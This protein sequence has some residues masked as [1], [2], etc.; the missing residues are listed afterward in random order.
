ML[1]W[2]NQFAIFAHGIFITSLIL[3][4]FPNL[5]YSFWMLLKTLTAFGLLAE[6]GL[7]R[8]IE[9][10][11]AF[12]YAGASRLP[13]NKTEFSEFSKTLD[14]VNMPELEK[15]LYT[16]KYIYLLLSVV[17]ILLLTTA[18]IAVLSNL[19]TQSG[20]D[21]R[22]WIAFILMIVQSSVMLQR[23]KWRSFMA[24]TKHLKEL[25]RLNTLVSVIRIFGFLALLLNNLGLEYLMAYLVV[26]QFVTYAYMRRFMNRWFKSRGIELKRIFKIDKTIFSSIWSVSW[27]TSLNS[28]GFFF[29]NRGVDLIIAQLKDPSLMAAYLFT[30][31]I[32]RF[33]R[34]IAQTPVTVKY[35]I[36][37]GLMSG[38]KFDQ[39]KALLSPRIFLS[40][41]IMIIG[42]TS[43]GLLGNWLLDLIGA[44][45]KSIV[46]FTIFVLLS[47]FLVFESHALIMGTI[48]VS[49]ND[50]PFLIPALITGTATVIIGSFVLPKWGLLGLISLQ[51]VL[52]L[53]NN[54]WYSAYLSL[55]LI[56]W[57]LL[58]YVKDV[59]IGGPRY[60]IS[61]IKY[62]K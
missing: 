24:G 56:H 3:V 14:T 19:F 58:T 21:H 13:K 51:M 44:E 2:T 53:G 27:K 55:R 16:I 28:W 37:Y 10:S 33:I 26:E 30:N 29:S 15:L 18:G 62:K 31:S 38:K 35:P 47:V 25:Y 9:R 40:L 4:K 61:R 48:Y 20:Q 8:T 45:S 59:V 42:F 52:N 57:P 43:F 50:V 22:L 34:K 60:W 54:F 11:V 6:A 49:T 39:V 41:S 12:F 17:T 23:I 7:G 46:P 5:D 36:V 32:L 1:S